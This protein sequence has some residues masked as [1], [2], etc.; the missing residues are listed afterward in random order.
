MP[1]DEQDK[2]NSNQQDQPTQ[3]QDIAKQA[4]EYLDGWKRAKADLANYKKDESKRFEAVLKFANEQIIRDAVLVLDSFDLAILALER[5]TRINTDSEARIDTDMNKA[6]EAKPGSEQS[7]TTGV[8]KGVFLIR[9]QLEDV[10]K[11]YGLERVVVSTGQNFDPALQEAV[12][13]IESDKPSG[14][15]IEE[16]EKGYTLNGRL[17]RPSRVKVAK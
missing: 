11:R 6:S 16:I 15:I 3:G 10:L 5:Q 7:S 14:T 8:E 2:N 17:V 9:A 4:E 13:S 1:Q 12:I